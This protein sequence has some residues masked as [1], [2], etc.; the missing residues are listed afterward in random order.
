VSNDEAATLT[1]HGHT[2]AV[3]PTL[4]SADRLP[5]CMELLSTAAAECARTVSENKTSLTGSL[6]LETEYV[7]TCILSY[8]IWQINLSLSLSPSLPCTG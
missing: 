7:P 4:H 5:H 1:G 2:C 6:P 3:N 8:V